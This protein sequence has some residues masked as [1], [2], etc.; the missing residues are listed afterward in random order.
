MPYTPEQP[1]E[2][3]SVALEDTLGDGW[4]QMYH[5]GCSFPPETFI[6][7]MTVL[8]ENPNLN[9]SWLFRADIIRD[10]RQPGIPEQPQVDQPPDSPWS[11]V[12][13]F[14]KYQLQ[15]RLVRTL[16]PRNTKRDLPL[17]QT[18]TQHQTL[19]QQPEDPVSTLI[20]YLPHVESAQETPFYHPKVKGVAHLHEWDPTTGTGSISV[21]FL[22]FLG[23]PLSDNK[24]QRTA[25][26]LLQIIHKHGESADYVKRVHHDMVVP[27]ATFQDR[28]AGLKGKYARRLIESWSEQTDPTK[29]IFED[30]GIAAFLIELWSCMYTADSPFPGFVDIGCGNG[31]LVHILNLE[32]Y[33]GWGFDARSR[34]SWEQYKSQNDLTASGTSLEERLLLPHLVAGDAAELHDKL[35]GSVGIHDGRFPPGTF[36]VSNHADELTPW[37]PL[38]AVASNCPFIS[39]PCCSHNLGGDKYR[40]PPP[41][42]KTK[43]ASTYASLVE[44]VTEIAED[45]GWVVETEFLRIPSTRNTALLGRSRMTEAESIDARAIID[46]HGGGHR[47]LENFMQLLKNNAR[48]H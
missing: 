25:F 16:V 9:S 37:T 27:R 1:S 5:H 13:H 32:G 14:P 11:R 29:H 47:Y 8:I 26:H 17:D 20:I 21:L 38:L 7:K 6:T 3:E 30:L 19:Q 24:L 15:R 40:P 48:G 36:I 33:H 10:E 31:L 46:K 43:G 34:R 22:P 45:C 35:P 28:Y 12:R 23:H 2:D 41:K 18:C 4:V 39:I 44:W 42:D